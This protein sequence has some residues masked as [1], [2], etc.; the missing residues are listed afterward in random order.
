M[1][2]YL[3]ILMKP[4]LLVLVANLP[5]KLWANGYLLPDQDAFAT[6]RGEA[7]T[8]TADNAAAVYYNPA[9]L[10]QLDGNNIRAGAYGIYLDP[11]F[12]P[13]GGSQTFHSQRHYAATPQ[14]F[15]S[16]G[17]TNWPVSFGLG[18]YSPFGL[19]VDWPQNTGFRTLGVQGRLSTVTINPVMAVKL[20][21]SLSVGGGVMVNYANINLQ[22]GYPP[23]LIPLVICSNSRETAGTWVTILACSGNRLS[24][25]PSVH[26]PQFRHDGFQRSYRNLSVRC[27]PHV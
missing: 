21:P 1:K 20:S 14:L 7:F 17:R 8:A 4:L 25:F 15:Y 9:G 22:Q 18:V 11:R 26:F 16:Y 19:A 6:A 12:T 10:S 2:R 23:I 24:R 5:L 3:R 13:P 27:T